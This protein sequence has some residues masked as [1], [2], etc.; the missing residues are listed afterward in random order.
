M[1]FQ[2]ASEKGIA[3]RLLMLLL[4][5]AGYP[6]AGAAQETDDAAIAINP[7]DFVPLEVGNRWTYEHR[8]S[9]VDPLDFNHS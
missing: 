7:L 3:M 6:A 2:T 5:L 8:Y 9:N 4:G 1:S